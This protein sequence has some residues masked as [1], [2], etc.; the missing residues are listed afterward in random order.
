M[1]KLL[2]VTF[3]F[4]SSFTFAQT[5][6]ITL[7]DI[8]TIDSQESFERVLIEN[9]FE[10]NKEGLKEILKKVWEEEGPKIDDLTEEELYELLEK[11]NKEGLGVVKYDYGRQ[12]IN[13]DYVSEITAAGLFFDGKFV[14]IFQDNLPEYSDSFYNKIFTEV[15]GKCK[16][17][18]VDQV[19][20]GKSSAVY[21]C[22]SAHFNN[23][24]GFFLVDGIGMIYYSPEGL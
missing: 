9:N 21:N 12:K 10:S 8:L 2:I 24:L 22:P 5:Y 14:F 23:K 20:D 1:K 15:K 17:E 4:F 3:I 16:F 7:D 18:E 11:M 6:N 19:I 13:D